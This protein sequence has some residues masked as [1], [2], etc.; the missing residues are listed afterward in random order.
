MWFTPCATALSRSDPPKDHDPALAV[1][2][3]AA[4]R[5]DYGPLFD[6]VRATG[7][8]KSECFNPALV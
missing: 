1:L 7:Q 2:R 8:R 4:I 5:D 6:F 3:E